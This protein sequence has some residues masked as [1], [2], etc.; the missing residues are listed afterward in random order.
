MDFFSVDC[1]HFQRRS[2]WRIYEGIKVHECYQWF[3]CK[4]DYRINPICFSQWKWIYAYWFYLNSPSNSVVSKQ[5]SPDKWYDIKRS[6]EGEKWSNYYLVLWPKCWPCVWIWIAAENIMSSQKQK[7]DVNSYI[8]RL[9]S[10]KIYYVQ[11]LTRWKLS[12]Y[13]R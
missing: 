5:F 4:R 7:M 8:R 6:D 11:D 13:F 9:I 10:N 2:V 12:K 1:C 3:Q